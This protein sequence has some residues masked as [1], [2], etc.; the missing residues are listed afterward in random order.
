MLM[1]L[2]DMQTAG[3]PK[4][5]RRRTRIWPTWSIHDQVSSSVG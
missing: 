3:Y 5:E 4:V 1:V 2:M